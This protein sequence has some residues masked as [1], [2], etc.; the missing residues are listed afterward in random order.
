M[1]RSEVGKQ[2]GGIMETLQGRRKEVINNTSSTGS[3]KRGDERVE[4]RRRE[5]ERSWRR[6]SLSWVGECGSSSV[7]SPVIGTER[8]RGKFKF[9]FLLK[10]RTRINREGLKMARQDPDSGLDSET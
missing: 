3:S 10:R 8:R 7:S 6:R 4:N 1:L 9:L 5:T 2:K